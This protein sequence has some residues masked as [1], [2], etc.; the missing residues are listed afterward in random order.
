VSDLPFIVAPKRETRIVSAVVNGQECSIEFPVFGCWLAAEDIAAREH[1]YQSATYA[2]TS[3]L[4]DA[5]IEAGAT[6]SDAQLTA[7]RIVSTRLGVPVQLGATDQRAMIRHADLIAGI[8]NHLADESKQW[9]LRVVAA[10]I[11]NRLPDCDDWDE[12]RAATL[13][14]P[15]RDAIVAFMDQERY[16]AAAGQDPEEILAAMAET[17]GKLGPAVDS[18][19]LPS[20]GPTASGGASDSGPETPPSAASGSPGSRP[21][22]SARRSKRASAG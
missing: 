11:A 12:T 4:A 7:V 21:R 20:T 13:P 19:P 16:G 14:G 8:V 1:E 15:I 6:E 18:S 3:R 5:L 9:N 2:E 17:L 22:S 10:A